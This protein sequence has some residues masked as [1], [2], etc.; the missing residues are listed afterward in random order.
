MTCSPDRLGGDLKR[1]GVAA[2][3]VQASALVPAAAAEAVEVGRQDRLD[4]G[5]R[6]P[7]AGKRHGPRRHDVVAFQQLD[8][9]RRQRRVRQDRHQPRLQGGKAER[10]IDEQPLAPDF[11]Q[12]QVQD[13]AEC[14]D[15]GATELVGASRRRRVVEALDH[16]IGDIADID[17]LKP[18][19]AA[20][21]QRQH[22][23]DRRHRREPVEELV[24]GAEHDR[25]AQDRRGREGIAHGLLAGGLG[26]GIGGGRA[27]IGADRRDVHEA[28]DPGVAGQPG[29]PGGSGMM[30]ELESLRP[31]F[32][33]DAD[34]VDE[35]RI[36]GEEGRQQRRIADRD[37][38]G[39]DLPDIAHRLQE[40][41]VLGVAAA[42]GD[43]LAACGEPPDHVPA[44]E[45]RP[46]EHGGSAISHGSP[47][48]CSPPA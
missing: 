25:G 32:T 3:A 46:A 44:D 24:F 17:R 14:V 7:Q 18:G 11:V 6:D 30:H 12:Q 15:L 4:G 22:R 20:A 5:R 8:L 2:K 27:R 21:D 33:Q 36:A 13:L 39:R 41:G 43:H 28:L 1:A 35:R 9:V 31:A 37:I 38:Q 29:E 40:L 42:D 23:R 48:A 47:V 10:Q 26:A 45:A 34:A 19:L 16:R